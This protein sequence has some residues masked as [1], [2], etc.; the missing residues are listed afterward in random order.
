M[1]IVEWR[2]HNKKSL[3]VAGWRKG[4][5]GEEIKKN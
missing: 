2:C 4:D 1:I 3:F 5:D